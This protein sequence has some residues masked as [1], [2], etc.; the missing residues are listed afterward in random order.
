[1][2]ATFWENP[3]TVRVPATSA[4]LGPG[5]DS[6]GLALTLYD[7]VTASASSGGTVI[8]VEG[9][10][11][12]EVPLDESHLIAATMRRTFKAMNV[13]PPG[14]TLSCLNRIPHARGL[15]SSSAAIVAG[16]MLARALLVDGDLRITDEELLALVVAIEGHPDNVAPCLLGGLVIAW[17][18]D[19]SAAARAVTLPVL[20][21][22]EPVVLVPA[23]G[24][25]T[26]LARSMLPEAVPHH[27][28]AVNAGRTALLIDALTRDFA[29]LLPATRDLLHQDQ[30]QAAMPDSHALMMR[31]RSAG[32]PAAISGAGPTVIAFLATE[33]QRA[34]FDQ[35]AATASGF[36]EHRLGVDRWG[37]TIVAG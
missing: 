19:D 14:I 1:M 6:L 29:T 23:T 8:E 3:V 13:T 16:A 10:G 28:A 17:S 11:A 35:V 7:E 15:G 34:A 5:F 22:I 30:R 27:D 36:R 37:A 9:E 24:V 25:K 26:E 20:E 21:G 33:E 4:N 31:L 2:S 18:D 32:V 12:D